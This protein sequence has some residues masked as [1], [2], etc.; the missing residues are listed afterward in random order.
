MNFKNSLSGKLASE[1]I[2]QGPA[3]DAWWREEVRFEIERLKAILRNPAATDEEKTIAQSQLATYQEM[4]A[5]APWPAD[6]L[7]QMY[8][9]AS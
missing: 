1:Q 4:S 3:K 5:M 6:W 8:H 2:K 9:L 7:G